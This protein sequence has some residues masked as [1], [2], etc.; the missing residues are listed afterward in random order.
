MKRKIIRI[1]EDICNGCGNCVPECKEG[2]IQI[3]EGKARLISDLFCDGLGACLGHCPEGAITIEERE[4][5]PYDERKVIE[6]LASQPASVLKAHLMHL[7]E[8]GETQLLAQAFAAMAL[9]GLRNPLIEEEAAAEA[10]RALGS[11]HNH[12]HH[13]GGGCPGSRMITLEQA[14]PKAPQ[15]KEKG[16]YGAPQLA[17]WPVQLHLVSPYAP[18]FRSKDLSII[19]T[20]SPLAS[21]DVHPRYL[22]G[23]ACVVACPKLDNTEPY[24]EKLAEIFKANATPKAIVVVMEVP[25]CKGLTKIALAARAFSG[26]EDMPIEE[27]TI[28]LDGSLK[29][30]VQY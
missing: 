1:D 13:G 11:M 19:S 14:A 6:S 2:A 3:I 7:R 18:Y 24:P 22:A 26:R 20:C 10:K 8:H 23:R 15:P 9:V 4:A 5:E 29:K 27:H 30:V 16:D 21:T 12:S 28:G 17:Q 25:C